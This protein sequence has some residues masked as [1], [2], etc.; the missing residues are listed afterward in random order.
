MSDDDIFGGPDED[1]FG[2][3]NEGFESEEG[4]SEEDEDED[5]EYKNFDTKII[6]PGD[7]ESSDSGEES[8]YSSEEED[9][10]NQQRPQGAG[11]DLYDN[12]Q[13]QPHAGQQGGYQGGQQPHAGQQGGYQGGQQPHAGQQGGYQGGQQGGY[14]GGQQGGYQSGHQA[15]QQFQPQGVAG[16]Q[17]QFLYDNRQPQGGGG[18]PLFGN[19]QQINREKEL[20]MFL[21]QSNIQKKSELS[22]LNQQRADGRRLSRAE[23]M[24]IRRE[25]KVLEAAAKAASEAATKDAG[26]PF[27]DSFQPYTASAPKKV[28]YN[29]ETIRERQRDPNVFTLA[30]TDLH[31]A[32]RVMY[33]NLYYLNYY[34]LNNTDVEYNSKEANRYANFKI[35]KTMYGTSSNIYNKH[36]VMIDIHMLKSLFRGGS[37]TMDDFMESL[38]EYINDGITE[39]DYLSYLLEEYDN[40]GIDI[41]TILTKITELVRLLKPNQTTKEKII[42]M[43]DYYKYINRLYLSESKKMGSNN[44]ELMYSFRNNYLNSLYNIVDMSEKERDIYM[45]NFDSSYNMVANSARSP[46]NNI[47]PI[48]SS[49][50]SM[51]MPPINNRGDVNDLFN[52]TSDKT[53]MGSSQQNNPFQDNR[54]QAGSSY[55]SGLFQDNS[56]RAGSSYQSGIFQDNRHQSGLFQD[57]SQLAGSPQQRDLFQD[58]RQ[59]SNLFQDNSQQAGNS[60]PSGLFQDN[61]QY[62]L[63]QPVSNLGQPM[64]NLGQPV[65]NL[66]Q[67]ASNPV[68][69]SLASEL[70]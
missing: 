22:M 54:Q 68:Q 31:W 25:K 13:Q 12:R 32:L 10:D 59:Q 42:N 43:E 30:E 39:I 66:E 58:N 6:I 8:D 67:P 33:I 50:M 20:A 57:N 37:I 38:Y 1:I 24:R 29:W 70:F 17:F 49:V 3:P 64:S 41:V 18:Q 28:I 15:G 48:D 45:S 16:Q 34:D 46:S 36:L 23:E 5:D 21:N 27:V 61:R 53:G 55:Q 35:N 40:S 11:R 52:N 63:G 26:K 51:F 56:Q 7:E 44:S 65:S 60:Q 2:G 4:E 62:N 14:Q 19:Q 9:D 69:Y 47:Q